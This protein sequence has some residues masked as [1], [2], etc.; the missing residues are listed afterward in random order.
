MTTEKRIELATFAG[1]CFWCMVAPFEELDG[2]ISVV[3]GYSGGNEVNPSYQQ[4]AGGETGH[5]EAVQISYEQGKVTY[6]QLLDIYWRQIDPTT[7]D[8]Q[9]ADEGAHYRTAIFYHNEQQRQLAE[10]SKA[11]LMKSGVFYTPVVTAIEPFKSFYPAEE[12]HQQYHSKNPSRY[13]FYRHHSGRDR[14]L[15]RVWNRKGLAEGSGDHPK[16][17]GYPSDQS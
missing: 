17:P 8:R 3:S 4:V 2:V 15:E 10:A 14:F 12:Y 1:G 6:Q 7:P 16:S 5:A 9:F 13:T 11:A